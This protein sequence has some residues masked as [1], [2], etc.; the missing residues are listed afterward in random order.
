[1]SK[2]PAPLD[3]EKLRRQAVMPDEAGDAIVTRDFLR[4]ALLE[5][6]IGR[7]ALVQLQALQSAPLIA[8]HIGPRR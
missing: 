7:D 4:R 8:E 1:V 6:E 2:L 5:L 3:L